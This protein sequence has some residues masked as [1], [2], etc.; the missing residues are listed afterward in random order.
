MRGNLGSGGSLG[1]LSISLEIK[2]K[3]LKTLEAGVL[4]TLVGG[5]R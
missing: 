5:W 2:E 3:S 4:W 1:I